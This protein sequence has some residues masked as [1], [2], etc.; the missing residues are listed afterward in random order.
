MKNIVLNIPHAVPCMNFEGWN[1]PE[2][3]RA[4]HDQWTDW[5]TDLLFAGFRN[6]GA[7]GPF[8][9]GSSDFLSGRVVALVSQYSRF[10]INIERLENDPMESIGRGD[11]IYPVQGWHLRIRFL[12]TALVSRMCFRV[13]P[14]LA[15]RLSMFASV[16]GA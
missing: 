5:Y 16:G 9:R 4:E 15:V 10:D 13:P 6:P 3:I 2:S 12:W 7:P 1:H 11:C 14:M 8:F